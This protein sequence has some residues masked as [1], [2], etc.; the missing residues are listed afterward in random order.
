MRVNQVLREIVASE[1]EVLAG[2]DERLAMVTV[3]AVDC[4][5]DLRRATVYLSSLGD[6]ARLALDDSR[7]RL[8]AAVGAQASLKFT[9]HLSF[10]ADPAVASGRRIEEI[11][12]GL[13]ARDDPSAGQGPPGGDG[14]GGGGA[15]G[16]A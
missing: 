2:A 5:R 4:E 13:A 7:V 12:R 14:A 6:D 3:T 10:V 15:G 8:Q 1:L 16:T 11:L 9:P